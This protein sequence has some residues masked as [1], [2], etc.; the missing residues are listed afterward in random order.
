MAYVAI[1]SNIRLASNIRLK[2]TYESLFTQGRQAIESLRARHKAERRERMYEAA[3]SLMVRQGYEG[4]TVD[5]IAVAADVSRATFFNYFDSKDAVLLELHGRLQAKVVA[6][7]EPLLEQAITARE[8]F[9]RHFCSLAEIVL[10]QG[11][12]VRV[13]VRTLNLSPPL[14]QKEQ[15][16]VARILDLYTRFLQEGVERCELRHDL[17]IPVAVQL[18]AGAWTITLLSFAYDLDSDPLDTMMKK[19]ELIFDGFTPFRVENAGSALRDS[20]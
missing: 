10:A 19:L 2:Y 4:T 9:E 6:I 17:D 20:P 1:D 12:R 7:T 16:V 5:D 8:R 3:W 18:V 15:E 14:R 11:D 13:L